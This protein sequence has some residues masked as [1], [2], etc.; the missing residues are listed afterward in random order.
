MADN[1]AQFWNMA[2]A[3]G[4]ALVTGAGS[5][6]ETG[7]KPSGLLGASLYIDTFLKEIHYTEADVIA[8]VQICEAA[9]TKRSIEFQDIDSDRS[10]DPWLL[11]L[12]FSPSGQ[13][14]ELVGPKRR[15]LTAPSSWVPGHCG[16]SETDAY[17][18]DI[19]GCGKFKKMG[20]Q[21]PDELEKC[22]ADITN[23]HVDHWSPHMANPSNTSGTE[24][25]AIEPEECD[26]DAPEDK[27]GGNYVDTFQ[28]EQ[29]S[30]VN[31]NGKGH[32]HGLTIKEKSLRQGQLHLSKRQY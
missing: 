23:I 6:E 4:L 16:R 8:V 11:H 21:N 2:G 5:V 20:L 10:L 12:G 13:R 18:M 14:E 17:S 31:P 3:K 9:L 7:R 26:R 30:P 15:A 24:S 27:I 28:F 19:L 29:E 1:E 25:N 32:Q 22:F